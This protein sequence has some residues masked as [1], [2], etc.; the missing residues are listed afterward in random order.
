MVI[1]KETDLLASFDFLT[2]LSECSQKF[3]QI[4]CL[5][6]L[7]EVLSQPTRLL[8]NSLYHILSFLQVGISFL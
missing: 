7:T 6:V 8:P 5:L 4:K 1:F 2:E 3:I